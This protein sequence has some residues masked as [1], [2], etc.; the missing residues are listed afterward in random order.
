MFRLLQEEQQ[1]LHSDMNKRFDAVDK[2]MD[3]LEHRMDRQEDELRIYGKK[4]EDVFQAR[5]TV[6]IKFGWEWGMV[7]LFIAL[8]ASGLMRVLTYS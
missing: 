4:L 1:Y 8:L 2:R 3:R 5:N 7:S 6:K